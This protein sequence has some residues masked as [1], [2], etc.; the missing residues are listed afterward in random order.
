MGHRANKG[1]PTHPY[2]APPLP[3]ILAH[4]GLAIG[5]PE[6]TLLAFL[7]ALAIDVDYLKTDVHATKDGIAVISHDP[8]LARLTGRKQRVRDLTARELKEIGLGDEQTFCTLA[9]ALDAFPEARF[10]IDVKSVDAVRPTAN[11]VRE[12]RAQHR[13]LITSFS[14]SRRRATVRLLPG[15]ASSASTPRALLAVLLATLPVPLLLLRLALRGID[16]VQLP[17]RVAGVR[18]PRPRLIERLHSAGVE[19]HLWTINDPAAMR[20]FLDLGIDGLVTDRADLARGL[21]E[22]D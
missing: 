18:I 15:V 5:A 17:E 22:R 6:N 14:E 10:N 1:S 13:V 16:A 21:I 8:D 11:A 19:I 2:F 3:R 7:H 20:G 4:R 9:E 12:A